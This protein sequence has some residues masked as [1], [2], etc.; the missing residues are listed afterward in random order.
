MTSPTKTLT[1]ITSIQL[2]WLT[3]GAT[4]LLL[5][6]NQTQIQKIADTK[7]MGLHVASITIQ[8]VLGAMNACFLMPQTTRAS[9]MT[10]EFGVWHS[11]R[12]F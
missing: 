7:E 1:A 5:N 11:T 6:T 12:V 4:N 8:D 3:R 9:V 10:C 2:T